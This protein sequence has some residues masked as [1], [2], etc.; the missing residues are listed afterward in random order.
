MKTVLMRHEGARFERDVIEP[1]LASFADLA[2]VVVIRNKRERTLRRIRSEYRRSGL[3][4]LT[5]VVAFRFFYKFVSAKR[6]GEK[7]DRLI[8]ETARELPPVPDDVPRITVDDPN[9]EPTKEFLEECDPD[10]AVARI[11]LLLDADVFT[12]PSAGTFVIHPGICPEYR[13]AH[14]CFWALA[15]GEPDK[16]GYTLLRIDDGIDTGP[17]YAQS[18]TDFD[19]SAD[20]H[21]YIQYKVVADNLDEI[22]TALEGAVHGEREPMDTRGRESDVW[23]QPRLSA[24]LRWKRR[25]RR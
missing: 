20:D 4:G 18:G 6:E 14:G 15:N 5:D 8:E 9:G 7:I 17:I 19:S 11:K 23:G 24:Y 16:V 22:A 13:N 3:V 10:A 1:W 12:I 21:L 25:A 2:G